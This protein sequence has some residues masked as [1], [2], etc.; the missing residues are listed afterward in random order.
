MVDKKMR[1]EGYYWARIGEVWY[2]AYYN[3]YQWECHALYDHSFD[4]VFDEIEEN[5]I[6][7]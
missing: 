5:K 4:S 6:G 2:V 3:G 7:K 1:E